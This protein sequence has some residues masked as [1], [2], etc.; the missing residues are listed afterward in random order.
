MFVENSTNNG[1]IYIIVIKID[2]R[3]SGIY[4]VIR[5]MEQMEMIYLQR[6]IMYKYYYHTLYICT[7]DYLIL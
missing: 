1:L 3:Y 2:A 5:K 4:N 6:Y 7:I